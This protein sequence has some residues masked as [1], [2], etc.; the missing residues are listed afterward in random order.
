MA[1]QGLTDN[2][3]KLWADYTVN[4][5]DIKGIQYNRV[6]TKTQ[7]TSTTTDVV[8]DTNQ[9]ANCGIITTMSQ[10]LASYQA[11][12]FQVHIDTYKD[13]DAVIANIIDYSGAYTTNGLPTININKIGS[14][15]DVFEI[16]VINTHNTNALSGVLQ[17][18][19]SIVKSYN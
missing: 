19:F 13:G 7:T 16:I 15:D 3:F 10:T 18:G 2:N 8:F 12:K 6:I 1:T 14:V 9:N 17:I 11:L 4:T 5:L